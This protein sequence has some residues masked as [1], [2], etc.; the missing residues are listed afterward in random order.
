MSIWNTIWL[1]C[2]VVYSLSTIAQI[3]VGRSYEV[4][5]E[6][7]TYGTFYFFSRILI[8]PLLLVLCCTGSVASFTLNHYA[9]MAVDVF[10]GVLVAVDLL[11][12]HKQAHQAK[13]V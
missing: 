3:F 10:V 7:F 9:D 12:L 5:K 4:L 1:V 11:L 6:S 2:M 13:I 8:S